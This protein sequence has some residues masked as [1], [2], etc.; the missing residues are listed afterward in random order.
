MALR[1]LQTETSLDE[2]I[3]RVGE[4]REVEEGSSEVRG[5]GRASRLA[6][7]CAQAE[8]QI[9]LCS[10]PCRWGS[11][12]QHQPDTTRRRVSAECVVSPLCS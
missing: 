12:G 10:V 4:P 9:M 1:C 2:I 8:R 6:A 11:Q 7:L 5:R 3:S